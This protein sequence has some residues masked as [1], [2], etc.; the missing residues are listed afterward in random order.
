M[1]NGGGIFFEDIGLCQYGN[2][3][4]RVFVYSV[5]EALTDMDSS[6]I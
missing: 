4:P 5:G 3:K 1:S 2:N 6:V